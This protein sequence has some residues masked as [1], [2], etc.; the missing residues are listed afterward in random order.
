MIMQ[1]SILLRC[2]YYGGVHDGGGN[3]MEVFIL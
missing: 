1:V 3:I 2:P